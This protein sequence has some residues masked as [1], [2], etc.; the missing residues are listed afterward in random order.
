MFLGELTAEVSSLRGVGPAISSRL[1]RL[2][3]TTIRDLLLFLPRG[4]ED[5]TAVV[6]LAQAVGRGK[7]AVRAKVDSV[8]DL[9]WGRGRTPKVVVSDG[10]AAASLVCFGNQPI[11]HRASFQCCF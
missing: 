6:P 1:E 11:S 3:I 9:G 7:A 10:T 2:G 4:Y 5:R 8:T